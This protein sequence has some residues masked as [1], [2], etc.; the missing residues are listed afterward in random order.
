MA[1][2]GRAVMEL[3]QLFEPRSRVRS[4]DLIFLLI[5]EN[6]FERRT[7]LGF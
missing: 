5:Q 3:V 4:H 2:G 7:R 1:V 6:L